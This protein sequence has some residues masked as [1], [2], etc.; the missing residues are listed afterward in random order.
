MSQ[1]TID[2]LNTILADLS[3]RVECIRGVVVSSADGLKIADRFR[4]YSYDTQVA[5]AISASI[6][7]LANKSVHNLGL[8]PF[9]RATIY[10]KDGIVTVFNLD[11]ASLL[12]LL[13]PDAN[14]GLV[15]IELQHTA[16][17]VKRVMRL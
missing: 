13:D 8:P 12:A 6:V 14:V 17:L 4:D 5:H 11:H 3:A 16:E 1:T 7:G 15:M 10:T 2:Q 9:D